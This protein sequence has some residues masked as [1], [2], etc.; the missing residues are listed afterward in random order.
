MPVSVSSSTALFSL[1][2][3]H[4]EF[5]FHCRFMLGSSMSKDN[6]FCVTLLIN[7]AKCSTGILLALFIYSFLCFSIWFA[8]ILSI[9][10]FCLAFRHSCNAHL[11]IL[12]LFNPDPLLDDAIVRRQQQWVH[13][14]T[15]EDRLAG[16]CWDRILGY[17]VWRMK[18][19]MMKW[20]IWNHTYLKCQLYDF[21][22]CY[23][24]HLSVQL[25]L[26]LSKIQNNVIKA[27]ANW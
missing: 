12:S 21:Y 11:T 27:S 4:M 15:P 20:E 24:I 1:K 18:R 2:R 6:F 13:R 19:K 8:W 16:Q 26:I 9:M 22:F 10:F 5:F 14:R 23:L 3:S 25:R 7:M 17:W